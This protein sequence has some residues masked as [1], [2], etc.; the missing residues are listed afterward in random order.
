MPA[1]VVLLVG[2]VLSSVVFIAELIVNCLCKRR[3]NVFTLLES[4]MVVLVRVS[5][6][7]LQM[8]SNVT[9]YRQIARHLVCGVR[10]STQ[11]TDLCL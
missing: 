6:F 11:K 1:F 8:Q 2:S 10:G 3:R 4:E 9:F 7:I 5:S